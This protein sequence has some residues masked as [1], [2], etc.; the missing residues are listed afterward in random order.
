VKDQAHRPSG[1]RRRRTVVIDSA[2]R[3]DDAANA[4]YR[5]RESSMI[6]FD[7]AVQTKRTVFIK[8]L[9]EDFFEEAE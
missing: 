1:W 5:V 8:R 4:C 3:R 9:D 6:R 7:I 2:S